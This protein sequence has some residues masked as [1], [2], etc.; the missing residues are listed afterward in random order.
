MKLLG[1]NKTEHPCY[2]FIVW[3][4]VSILSATT[5]D[6]SALPVAGGFLGVK[7]QG[8]LEGTIPETNKQGV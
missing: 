6:I 8:L 1:R 7:Q 2:L 5:M 4:I 3:K